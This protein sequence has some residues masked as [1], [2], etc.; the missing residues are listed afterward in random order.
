MSKARKTAQAFLVIPAA[1]EVGLTSVALG[2][3]RSLQNLGVET[4]FAKPIAEDVPD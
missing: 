4:S 3:V 2:L 1:P